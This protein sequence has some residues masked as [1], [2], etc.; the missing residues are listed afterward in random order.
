MSKFDSVLW[1]ADINWILDSLENSSHQEFIESPPDQG[2]P[3]RRPRHSPKP[4]LKGDVKLNEKQWL[5]LEDL[6]K[7]PSNLFKARGKT[8]LSFIKPPFVKKLTISDAASPNSE[9]SRTVEI[10]L[11]VHA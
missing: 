7:A 1:P 8:L 9:T 6:S 2:P 11:L 10:E 4:A 5:I 3:H